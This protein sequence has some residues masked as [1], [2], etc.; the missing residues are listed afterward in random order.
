[1]TPRS[2]TRQLEA[3]LAGARTPQV[4]TGLAARIVGEVTGL[5][6]QSP[7]EALV[8]PTA[9]SGS[10]P[11]WKHAVA[12]AALMLVVGATTLVLSGGDAETPHGEQLAIAQKIAPALSSPLEAGLAVASPLP[13]GPAAAEANSPKHV[14]AAS[15]NDALVPPVPEATEL[16]IAPSPAP[17]EPAPTVAQQDAIR[18]ATT[19]VE[20]LPASTPI[21]GPSAPSQGFGITGGNS[22]NMP[23]SGPAGGAGSGGLGAPPHR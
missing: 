1:M 18:P 14:P 22:T 12:A 11:R 8:S 6:Q 2:E 9:R 15:N 13:A 7:A 5:P 23:R 4:P 21:Y 3:A 17:I 10:K 16:A 19:V 20:P